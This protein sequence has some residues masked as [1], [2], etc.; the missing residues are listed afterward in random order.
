MQSNLLAIAIPTYKRPEI[1]DENIRSMLP[2]IQRL[3]VPVYISDDSPDH[4]TEAMAARLREIYEHIYYTR[5]TPGLGHDL[6]FIATVQLPASDYVWYLG[7]AAIINPGDLE[8]VYAALSSY[9]PDLLRRFAWHLTLT[10]A[11]IYSRAAVQSVH[12][13]DVPRWRNFPQLGLIFQYALSANRTAY[14][15]GSSGVSSNR[16]KK[17]YWSSAVVTT[18]AVDW[19]KIL[20]NISAN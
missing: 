18:F 4:E 17:S 10:G 8:K 5:N 9:R 13:G 20:R 6:N 16:N 14:W 3:G 12:A 15:M 1:L 2:E 19:V 7:D 11:T